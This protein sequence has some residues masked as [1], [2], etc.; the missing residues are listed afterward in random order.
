ASDP[1]VTTLAPIPPRALPHAQRVLGRFTPVAAVAAVLLITLLA[2]ALFLRLGRQTGGIGPGVT[3]TPVQPPPT[4]TLPSAG[5][6]TAT[7]SG[8]GQI[9]PDQC[10]QVCGPN[11]YGIAASDTAVW[12]LNGDTGTLLRIDPRTN[13]IVARIPVGHGQGGVAIGQGAVWVTA[14]SDGKSLRI[15]PQT[16]HVVATITGLANQDS[17]AGQA[18][19]VSPGAVWATDLSENAVIRIDSQTSKVVATIPNQL[20]ATGASYG[21]GSVWVC[22]TAGG[23]QALVRLDPQTNQVQAQIHVGADRVLGCE[24]VVAKDKTVWA[25]SFP[26][27]APNSTAL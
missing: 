15:D 6:I 20:M 12:I 9:S 27:D 5:T 26:A 23:A 7:I 13:T 17:P 1:K 21:A 19:A 16:N 11:G 2:S 4:A 25:M 10:L 8:L 24:S 14:P 3:A 18:I 22:N